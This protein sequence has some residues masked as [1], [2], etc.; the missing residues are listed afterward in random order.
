M[1]TRKVTTL[2]ASKILPVFL[3]RSKA[4]YFLKARCVHFQN[5]C[6]ALF[7]CWKMAFGQSCFFNTRLSINRLIAMEMVT[8]KPNDNQER[9]T[10]LLERCFDTLCD[11]GL[12]NTGLK[13]L[14]DA[15]GLYK[16]RSICLCVRVCILPC[17]R[18]RN[19]YS[20]SWIRS[21]FPC[22]RS[23]VPEN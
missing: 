19:I 20:H 18:M 22:G 12:E 4:A 14:A 15:C 3:V 7:S 10:E 21:A 1:K 8:I 13:M 9:R 17:L 16:G 23:W 2:I 6:S 5:G 11:H